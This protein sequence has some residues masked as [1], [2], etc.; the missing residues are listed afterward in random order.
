VSDRREPETPSEPEIP[1]ALVA[2]RLAGRLLDR[3][4]AAALPA[5][6]RLLGAV[7]ER[8]GSARATAVDRVARLSA[9]LAP[10]PPGPVTSGEPAPAGPGRPVVGAVGVVGARTAAVV[11]RGAR[12]AV[13]GLVSMIVISAAASMLQGVDHRGGQ[14]V[15]PPEAGPG[16]PAA[17]PVQAPTVTVGPYPGDSVDA[18]RARARDQLSALTRAAP[19]ADLYAVVSLAD[20]RTPTQTLGILAD[21]RTVRVFFAAPGAGVVRS[22]EVRDPV[23]DVAAAF[24]REAAADDVRARGSADAAERRR[25]GREA[26]ELRAGCACLFAAVVRAPAARLAELADTPAVRLVDAAPPGTTP[27]TAVFVPLRPG[28]R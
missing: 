23:A 10:Q 6:G 15:A 9:R 4:D 20:Y 12:F 19:Q 1:S 11:E 7:A 8:A 22:A 2:A 17:A 27:S 14:L 16:G 26:A 18:Y 28:T 24:E 3:L 5:A 21:Y 13:L 25:A